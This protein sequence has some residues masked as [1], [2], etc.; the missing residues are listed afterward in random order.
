MTNVTLLEIQN[1][2]IFSEDSINIRA[3]C[4]SSCFVYY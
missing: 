4:E 2:C 3:A 1:N